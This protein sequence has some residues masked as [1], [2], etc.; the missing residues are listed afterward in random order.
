MFES[1]RKLDQVVLE[2]GRSVV[3]FI[4]SVN[5]SSDQANFIVERSET[6]KIC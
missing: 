4:S 6:E 2:T 1:V 5:E 3:D